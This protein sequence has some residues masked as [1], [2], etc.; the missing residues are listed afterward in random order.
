MCSVYCLNCCLCWSWSLILIQSWSLIRCCFRL[1]W[2]WYY[3]QRQND[4][5]AYHPAATVRRH[6]SDNHPV[7]AVRRTSYP[8]LQADPQI[9][10][11]NNSSIRQSSASRLPYVLRLP[12]RFH[13]RRKT[14]CYP[15]F[16]TSRYAYDPRFPLLPYQNSTRSRQSSA[17]PL[18]SF[19]LP[20]SDNTIHCWF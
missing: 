7:S 12:C 8:V 19:H 6:S 10:L 4:V 5:P 18:P 16:C 11:R 14:T 15:D 17:I 9:L 2:F 1:L 20:D 13:C 3:N